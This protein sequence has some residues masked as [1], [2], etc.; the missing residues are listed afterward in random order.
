[1]GEPAGIGPEL[2]VKVAQQNFEGQLI[3]IADTR[4]LAQTAAHLGL[5]LTLKEMDWSQPVISHQP[6]GLFIEP[7]ELPQTVKVGQLDP[8]N[9]AA[10]LRMLSRASELALANRV[11]A[12]VT[13]PVHK[14]N[15]N[16]CDAQFLGHTEFFAREANC[17]HVVMML[18][19]GPL[20]ICLATTHLPL[21]QV[22]AAI[23]HTGLQTTINLILSAFDRLALPTPRIA[24][25]G[26]NPHAGEG[27]LL[28]HE[29]QEIIQPVISTFIDA[30]HQVSGPFPADTL[31]TP[32]K[33]DSF[34]VAL[35]MFHDQGLPVVKAFGFGQCANITLGL[36]YIRTSVDHGTALDIAADYTASAES[37]SYAINYAIQLASGQL[38]A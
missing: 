8:Q 34:D 4:V 22:P 13:G 28:G 27:G 9:A 10:T 32:Q 20:R 14:A 26:L 24:V 1:M 25:C 23:T 19:S 35:A 5:P 30:G 3:A 7:V 37:L 31:F 18:A 15:L 36:P 16:T 11:D 21:A 12:I 38:P 17:E 29:E 6:G 33:R 2:L